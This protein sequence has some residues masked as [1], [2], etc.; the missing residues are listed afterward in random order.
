MYIGNVEVTNEW[1]KLETLIQEQVSGQSAFSFDSAVTYQ[2]Q[3]E[4]NYGIRLCE[5]AD[6]PTDPKMGLRIKGTQ[7]AHYKVKSGC[8]VY[9][10]TEDGENPA[11]P[12]L[13]ISTIGEE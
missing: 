8:D 11:R 9:V 3:G 5:V 10:K 7:S 2:L 1:Q 4:G 12:L 6:A 13:H